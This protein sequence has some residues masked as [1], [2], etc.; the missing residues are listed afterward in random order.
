M[1]RKRKT[2]CG[3]PARFYVKANAYKFLLP[4]KIRDPSDGKMKFWIRLAGLGTG[5]GNGEAAMLVAL[6]KLLGERQ[7]D[8]ADIPHLCQE[9]K[10]RKLGRYSEEV[11]K[12]YSAYLNLIADDFEEFQVKGVM[13]RH[14]SPS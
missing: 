12:Q 3:L 1:S 13:T 10:I 4:E 14:W 6:G 7:C 8:K 11:Q 5:E 2:N 9:F